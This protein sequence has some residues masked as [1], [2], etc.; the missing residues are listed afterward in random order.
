MSI[1]NLKTARSVVFDL[2]TLVIID[3]IMENRHLNFS[4]AVLFGLKNGD[5]LMKKLLLSRQEQKLKEVP[6]VVKDE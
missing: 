6:E 2:E 5:Y 1:E 3:K 4:K